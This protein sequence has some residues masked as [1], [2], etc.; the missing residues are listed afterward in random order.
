M[1]VLAVLLV[2]CVDPVPRLGCVETYGPE[3]CVADV[4]ACFVCCGGGDAATTYECAD[5]FLVGAHKQ[6]GGAEALAA[7]CLGLDRGRE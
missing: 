4:G 1:V 2:G 6:A 5:G 3:S 7:H